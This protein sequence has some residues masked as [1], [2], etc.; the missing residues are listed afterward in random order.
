[1]S[2]RERIEARCSQLLVSE[3]GCSVFDRGGGCW[4]R[5]GESR[6]AEC[7]PAEEPAEAEFK[8][9]PE[10]EP[11]RGGLEMEM[12]RLHESDEADGGVTGLSCR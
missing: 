4:S 7:G 9:E 1:M 12:E 10:Q 5:A 2:T 3:V 6:E 8:S 11:E